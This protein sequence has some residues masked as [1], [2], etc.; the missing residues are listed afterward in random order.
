MSDAEEQIRT[1]TEL[2]N[3]L[4]AEN[5]RLKDRVTETGNVVA[6][7]PSGHVEVSG[8]MSNPVSESNLVSEKVYVYVPRERKCPRFSGNLAQDSLSVGDWVE[9]VRKSLAA[10]QTSL[11]EQ[12]SFVC[13][14]LDGEAKKEVKFSL[15]NGAN[16]EAIFDILLEN[17]GCDQTYV[18]LQK[19]F[20]QRRQHENESIREFSHALL[21]IMEL[22]KTRDPRGVVNP[23]LVIRDT[24]IENVRDYKL[25]HELMQ[26]V[27]QYPT[28]SFKDVRQA[29]IKWEKRGAP[30]STQRARAYSCDSHASAVCQ[31]SADASAITARSGDELGE[32]KS[33]FGSSRPNLMPSSND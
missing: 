10:R 6:P 2:V 18:T 33:A 14:L 25:Q 16:P 4:Q 1:L 24:F 3:Q 13:D 23:D 5:N 21:E 7:G 15:P 31:D 19:Q 11:A 30:T 8:A 28:H 32:L 9:E 26:L 22:L 20:F 12:V 17:F 29:A 27:R